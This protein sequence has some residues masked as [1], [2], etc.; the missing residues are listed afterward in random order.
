[1]ATITAG[2]DDE[3]L[4]KYQRK[5]STFYSWSA[6]E[7]KDFILAADTQQLKQL[8]EILAQAERERG[9]S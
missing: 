6:T 5:R 7:L 2:L 3:Q 4:S 8:I 9:P 1:M